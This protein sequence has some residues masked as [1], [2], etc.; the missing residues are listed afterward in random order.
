MGKEGVGTNYR[1]PF[2]LGVL[3]IEVSVFAAYSQ[4]SLRLAPLGS[5]LHSMSV[6]ERCPSYRES[7]KIGKER[8]GPTTR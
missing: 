3:L 1:Y 8:L 2:W 4:L 5:A 7:T 6:L